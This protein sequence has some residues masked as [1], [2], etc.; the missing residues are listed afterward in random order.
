MFAWLRNWWGLPAEVNRLSKNLDNSN[1]WWGNQ[2][3][4]AKA[5]WTHNADVAKSLDKRLTYLES[6]ET[7]REKQHAAALRILSAIDKKS[8][9][10][11]PARRSKAKGGR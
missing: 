4:L 3:S 9:P 7:E 6:R 8:T 2:I 10:K 11:K 1:E 5:D